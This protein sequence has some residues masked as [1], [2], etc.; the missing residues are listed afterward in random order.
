[1]KRFF[2]AILTVALLAAPALAGGGVQASVRVRN[3]FFNRQVVRVRDVG[4]RNRGAN[5]Q[6]NVNTGHS[7]GAAA[8]VQVFR[9][10]GY[11]VGAAVVRDFGPVYVPPQANV[12]FFRQADVGVYSYGSSAQVFRAPSGCA[13]G[14]QQSFRSYAPLSERITEEVIEEPV[15]SSTTTT[16]TTTE[17][18]GIRRTT[19]QRYISP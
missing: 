11:N 13:S 12:R 3:G 16:T 19:V 5:V 17:T 8:G 14:V 10:H 2:F 7:Y 4:F 15:R 1:M 9:S 6:F 18:N